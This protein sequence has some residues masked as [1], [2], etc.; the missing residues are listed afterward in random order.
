MFNKCKVLSFYS[1]YSRSLTSSSNRFC[2]LAKSS[3][4]RILSFSK[5]TFYSSNLSKACLILDIYSYNS[6]S[7]LKA[8][9]SSSTLNAY[10]SCTVL[11]CCLSRLAV[12]IWYS[13]WHTCSI[14]TWK[15]RQVFLR[16]YSFK[17][18]ESIFS[19]SAIPSSD[20]SASLFNC[21]I[22]CAFA[23]P[24]L[25]TACRSCSFFLF[26]YLEIQILFVASL[27]I[28]NAPME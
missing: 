16:M 22:T 1:K 27:I 12:I 2:I 8:Y 19:F 21:S 15:T 11:R 20:V 26:F 18:C 14:R 3:N 24:P 17:P 10:R 4:T 28:S 7:L 9:C 25:L 23:P 5:P 13:V 6:R